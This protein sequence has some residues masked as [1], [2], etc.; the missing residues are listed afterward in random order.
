LCKGN[1]IRNLP[2]YFAEA[3]RCLRPGGWVECQE[4][5]L[6]AFSDDDSLPK[7]SPIVQWHENLHKGML[8]AGCNLRGTSQ[9]LRAAMEDAGFINVRVIDFKFPLSP[10]ARDRKLKQAG[11][12]A[13]LSM[14]DDL[15]GISLAVFTRLLG[16]HQIELELFLTRVKQDWRKSSI[17]AYWPL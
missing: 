3:Y 8:L 5:D 17:H 9:E 10:W 14:M 12:F 4:T 13:M 16:W 7:D 11:G 2:K 6:N 1:A 15:S